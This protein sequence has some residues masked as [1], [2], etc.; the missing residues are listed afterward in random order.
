[1]NFFID[2]NLSPRIARALDVLE[3]EHGEKVVHLKDKFQ[4]DA[5]DEYWM[6]SLGT[7][8]NWIVIT[9]DKRIS[10]NPH[11]I[12]AWQESGLIVFFL[13][14]SWLTLQFWEQTW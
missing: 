10:R 7:E 11:E 6:R 4:Q 3:G 12:R 14:S 2:N 13:K 8:K 5:T 9:C 1:M